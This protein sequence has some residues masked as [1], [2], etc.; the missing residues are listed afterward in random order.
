MLRI[1]FVAEKEWVRKI[2]ESEV[3]R[4]ASEEAWSRAV[5]QGKN[6]D[7]LFDLD[8]ETGG[9][10]YDHDELT[11]SV[12]Y[13][14]NRTYLENRECP[15]CEFRGEV[16]VSSPTVWKEV[17]DH[18]EYNDETPAACPN[19]GHRGHLKDWEVKEI[20]TWDM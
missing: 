15:K 12:V 2:Q 17:N 18:A 13:W 1:N 10:F 3:C 11:E 20:N 8:P 6:W 7:H 9:Y 14:L 16:I 4:L 5:R 19:C